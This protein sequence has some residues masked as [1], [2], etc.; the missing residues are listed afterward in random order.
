MD[1]VENY[2]EA[3]RHPIAKR[4]SVG[5]EYGAR[6][7]HGK[8][9]HF[10][11]GLV[12]SHW[13]NNVECYGIPEY[14]PS[15]N[16]V[17]G[18]RSNNSESA[19]FEVWVSE[20]SLPLAKWIL[21]SGKEEFEK[22]LPEESGARASEDDVPSETTGV[23][24]LCFGEFTE[25]I[26]RCPNCGVPLHAARAEVAAEESA[27]RL[28]NLAH[29]EFIAQLRKSLHAAGIPF[30]NANLSFGDIIT[31]R[32]YL[33]NYEVL[34]LKKDF[35]RATQVMSQV[36]QHWEFEPSAGFG[37]GKDPLLDYWA[38]RGTESGWFP[39]DISA[40]ALSSRN[41]MTVSAICR[42]LREHEIPYRVETEQFRTAKI[43]VHPDDEARAREL[44]NEVVENPPPE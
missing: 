1:L 16:S 40:L 37:I 31:G 33:P 35:E 27:W 34:V 41:I 13:N 7:W 20:E 17:T 42:A 43:L 23:C 19:E 11:V 8:D 18:Q 25:A 6:L 4:V 21:D 9:P 24:P 39:E 14:P 2:V 32:R 12:W 36:L 38:M 15:P 44:G 28:C 10:Y 26:S 30:N 3:V 5:D 22:E 29:P